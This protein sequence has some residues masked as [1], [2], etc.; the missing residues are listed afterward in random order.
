[1]SLVMKQEG[2]G[3]FNFWAEDCNS[4]LKAYL[5][6]RFFCVCTSLLKKLFILISCQQFRFNDL[7]VQNVQLIKVNS[8][9]YN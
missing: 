6:F 3:K 7:P 2:K 1:M 8:G 9:G 4:E 5:S